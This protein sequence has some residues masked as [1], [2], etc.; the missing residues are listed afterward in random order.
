VPRADVAAVLAYL[1][2]SNAAVH[3]QFELI[4]GDTPIEDA[5]AGL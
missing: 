3:A 1:L 2:E 4:S 5:L